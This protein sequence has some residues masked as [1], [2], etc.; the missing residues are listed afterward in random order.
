MIMESLTLGQIAIALTFIVGLISSIA[1]LSKHLKD[2]IANSLK[3]PFNSINSKIED[4]NSRIKTVDIEA[5]KNYLVTFLS[6]VE[7]GKE[8]NEI[9]R[10]RFFEQYQHYIEGGGNSYIKHKVEQLKEKH[11]L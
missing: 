4:M 8:I 11:K 10:E 3:E 1:Y 5:C 2:W 9:E 6:D 7:R